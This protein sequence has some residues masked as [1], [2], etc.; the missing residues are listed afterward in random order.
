[1]F[2]KITKLVGKGINKVIPKISSRKE[3][4]HILRQLDKLELGGLDKKVLNG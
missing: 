4:K 3:N 2:T 1:M